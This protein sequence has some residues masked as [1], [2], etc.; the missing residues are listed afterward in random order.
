MISPHSEGRLTSEVYGQL[1][2]GREVTA[3]RLENRSGATVVILDYGGII[4]SISVP[5]ADG[6]VRNVTLGY[7]G[8]IP[9]LSQERYFG[10]LIG[11]FAG[12]I[13]GGK[14]SVDGQQYQLSLN[15]P[16]HSKHGG[17]SGFDKKLW[18][19]EAFV[20]TDS[21]GVRLS[22]VSEDGEEGYPGTLRTT[23]TYRLAE[24]E[25]TLRIDYA[26]DTDRTTAVNLTN[27]AYFN[28]AG[29]GT[30]SIL[31][32]E[33]VLGADRYLPI[34]ADHR[35]LSALAPVAGTPL[36]FTTPHRIGARIRDS[37]PQI[38]NARG[39]DH[40]YAVIGRPTQLNFGA[41]VV[42]PSSRRTLEVWTTEP[43]LVFYTGN[44]LDGSIVGTS[45]RAY[46][47]ADGFALE[48]KRFADPAHRQGAPGT[49]LRPG[50]TYTAATEYRFGVVP[51]AES[52]W[53]GPADAH[54]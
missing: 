42:E 47:Q 53:H 52:L 28:L 41:R 39:Y 3:H 44:L 14:L 19:A 21:A 11:R 49:T 12:R 50:D 46:R 1:P 16:P 35:P 30:G 38:Q 9:Y 17:F 32:H 6:V 8:L 54:Q 37:S 20:D 29:E 25:N 31:D 34:D 40:Q 13:P 45:G 4:Q 18:S 27:H 36:D 5:D 23:V 26:A 48:P 43:C 7:D 51:T 24:S 10:A 15:S 22:Y 2:D 33:L